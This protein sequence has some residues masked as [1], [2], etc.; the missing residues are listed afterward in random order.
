VRG[1]NFLTNSDRAIC[2]IFP[3]NVKT[4]HSEL[5]FFHGRRIMKMD[6]FSHL[7]KKSKIIFKMNKIKKE[8]GICLDLHGRKKSEDNSILFQENLETSKKRTY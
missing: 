7:R 1:G 8:T 6:F 5:F 4:R 3:R 2:L